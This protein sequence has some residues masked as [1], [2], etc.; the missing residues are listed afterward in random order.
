MASLCSSPS[1]NI[2]GLINHVTS[3]RRPTLVLLHG[4]SSIPAHVS[5]KLAFGPVNW[6]PLEAVLRIS[7]NVGTHDQRCHSLQILPRFATLAACLF[8]WLV[9]N[10][11][12]DAS[13]LY[14]V[15]VLL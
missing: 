10:F 8:A 3:T 12:I 2:A 1:T 6:W 4:P 9:R 5:S 15:C 11:V 7:S 13:L 14:F